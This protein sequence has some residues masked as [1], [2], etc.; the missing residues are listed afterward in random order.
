MLAL[1]TGVLA[2]AAGLLRLGFLANFISEPV[3]K[4]F[5]IGLALTI[6]IGQVPKLLGIEKAEGNFFEQLWGVLTDLGDTHGRTLV[7][8]VSS[9]ALVLGLRRFAPV[10]PGSLVA[11]IFGVV[12]VELFDLDDKGVD[13]RRRHRQR[14][15][16]A[17]AARRRRLRRLPARRRRGGR[18]HARRVRR[19]TRRG[20][21][22]RRREH[23]EIDPNRELLGLGAANL[24]AGLCSGHGR[25][26]QPLEDGRQRL[27]RRPVAGVGPRRRRR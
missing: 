3:L 13:D 14:S 25:Q 5:I 15:P 20:Q 18:D 17:R 6:I 16:V 19:G 10:V 4:G 21:D 1:V 11:V 22:V 7:V 12:A 26:R 8:G 24:G 27:G 23:Y 9:L 2:L